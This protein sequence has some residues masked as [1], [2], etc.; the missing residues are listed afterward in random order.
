[1]F[2]YDTPKKK[3]RWYI[4]I[5]GFM[6]F[7]KANR[8]LPKISETERQALRAGTLWIDGEI[9]N[10]NPDFSRILKE[11]YDK[12]TAEEQAFLDGPT[13]VLCNMVNRYEMSETRCIPDEALKFAKEKGFMAMLI[14]KKY[15]GLEFSPLAISTILSK[16][17][18]FAGPL[19]TMILIASSLGAAELLV[20]YGTEEQ[21][22]KYLPKLAKA[23]L[24]PCFALTE[25]TAGSDAASMK[26]TGV[27]FKDSNGKIKIKVNFNKRYIT[28]AP[29]S[30]FISLAFKLQDPEELLK[31]GKDVG[32]TVAMLKKDLPGIS[33]GLHHLPIGDVFYNG[34]L[35]GKDVVIDLD[36][37]IGG[38]E[39]AGQGWRML[40]EQLAGGRAITLPAGA[41]GGMK[42][43]AAATGAYSMIRYQFGIPIGQME[44]IVEKM[45]KMASLTY[46][47]NGARI[48]SCSSVSRGQKPPVI[49]AIMKCY[50]TE[51]A[52]HLVTDAM[53]I[54]AG[55]GVMLG[56]NNVLGLSYGGTAVGIT[57]EGANIMTRSLIIFAQ[58]AIRC[59][60]Y[61]YKVVTA[62]EEENSSEF[63]GS[64]LKWMGHIIVS[65]AR[66]TIRTLTRGFTVKVP[67]S[68]PL[69]TYYRRLGWAASRF[70]VLTDLAIF[71]VGG[72]LKSRGM[73]S[74]RF[75]DV[76]AWQLIAQSAL[77]RYEAE[78]RIKEDLPLVQ[79]ACE[80]ALNEIQ[81][82]FE[83]IYENF[84]VPVFGTWMKT[85]GLFL[86]RF[87]P[88]GRKPSDYLTLKC[89]KTLQNLDDQFNRITEDI[90][91]PEDPSAGVGR[92]FHAFKQIQ[93]AEGAIKKILKAQ[94]ER[95]IPRGDPY[96]FSATAL[97]EGVIN[98]A[99]S[100]LIN[101][102]AQSRYEAIQVDNFT[103][104]EFFKIKGIKIAPG[105]E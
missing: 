65:N 7:L 44:G 63:L 94:K 19:G 57:V 8:I 48:F 80:Y 34:P 84:S 17:G 36:D 66:K 85:I 41:V 96:D 100:D 2:D 91:I 97:K 42:N 38:V 79:Y 76:L 62:V 105:F 95:K 22:S 50:S 33:I 40:M 43:V 74:A 29:V 64:M 30:N 16:I 59:H 60:P 32:I 39:Y 92:L 46:A 31:K 13:E 9:F 86:L 89:A 55:S 28:L 51:Y 1:M 56:P 37:I 67:V 102:A 53:D 4:M 69:A 78:G 82:A 26:A 72:K 61:A 77:R 11:P 5:K 47:F 24:I 10:G 88:V 103:P 25:P 68:G 54:F 3:N 23:E 90:Y 27:V 45:G 71:L 15:G 104:E 58:G 20:H 12:L 70:A 73:L 49:S 98:T 81:L 87:N 6:R 93:A 75:A 83:G 101:K 99:E 35:Q 52:R 18:P 14:P 21:K